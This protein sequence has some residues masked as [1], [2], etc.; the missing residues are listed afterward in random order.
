MEK[1]QSAKPAWHSNA[2]LCGSVSLITAALYLPYLGFTD[3]VH[4]E[5]R[6]A[7][8]A[9]TMMETG[10]YLVP[11]LAEE[12]YLSKPPLF[13]WL[14][15]LASAP[16]GEVTE[17]TARLPSVVALALTAVVMV[18]TAGRYLTA[19]GRW[20]L[21]LSLLVMLDFMR[22]G[23]MA[24]TEVTFTLLVTT[25]LW[26]WFTLDQRGLRGAR[27]WFPPALAV[28]AAYL[29]KREP[30]LAFYYLAI[31]AY[32]IQAGRWREL[33]TWPA[34]LAGAF[35]A[36][37]I[38][39]WIAMVVARSG[40]DVWLANFNEQVVTRGLDGGWTEY[41]LSMLA[42]PAQ[43]FIATLPLSVLLIPLGWRR[44]RRALD[45]RYG[46]AYRFAG[47]AVLVNLPLYWFR[48]KPEVRYFEPMFPT[49]A[50]LAVMVFDTYAPRPGALPTYAAGLLRGGTGMLL[51]IGVLLAVAMVILAVPGAVPDVA[52]PLPGP[53][54][55]AA[56]GLAALVLLG[57]P[58]VRY[59]NR[60]AVM[61]G[62]AVLG[63][64][65]VVR[66][67]WITYHIPHEARR[68]VRENDD[69]P[70]ILQQIRNTLPPGQRR[71]QALG[72]IPHA[73]WFY[74]KDGLVVPQAR[75]TR[76]GASASDYVLVHADDQAAL[77][78]VPAALRPISRIPYEDG[79]FFLF[80]LDPPEQQRTVGVDR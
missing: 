21:G 13:N 72:R 56:L 73:I 70:A 3:L 11:Q 74:D 66:A 78:R 17:F 62:V 6:K 79:D 58:T 47:L 10:D 52:R 75:L 4:E 54:F 49:L 46:P 53:L 38:G 65:L 14:I 22:Q 25:S 18:L 80:R 40:T 26:V 60:F 32:L 20:F 35:T 61:L 45:D 64:G 15:A 48:A 33:L 7:V 67:G 36:G 71:V 34:V 39:S 51:G 57:V 24:V 2:F 59:R 28:I 76:S 29:A 42:Y 30:A 5:T 8:I 9:R 44:V 37:A 43:L 69:V 50:V 1:T 77:K 16:G 12:V 55:A 31:G 63:T 41:L 23:A 19:P 68:I 27:L